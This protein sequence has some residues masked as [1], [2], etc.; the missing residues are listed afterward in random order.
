MSIDGFVK[1]LNDEVSVLSI[2]TARIRGLHRKMTH[3][4]G[5]VACTEC[6]QAWPCN[7]TK[8]LNGDPE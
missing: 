1:T 8:A 7:T 4:Y 6:G 3:I 5:K 2:A